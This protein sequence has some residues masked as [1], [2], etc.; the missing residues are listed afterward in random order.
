MF[1][2][3]NKNKC[4]KDKFQRYGKKKITW[5]PFINLHC[6]IA[7]SYPLFFPKSKKKNSKIYTKK[8]VITY[9]KKINIFKSF[10]KTI[11]FNI[12]L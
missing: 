8:K 4:S 6:R 2:K 1:H 5:N 7:D 12:Q 3:F 9:N 11:I 10:S